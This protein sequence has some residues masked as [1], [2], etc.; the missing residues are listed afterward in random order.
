[1]MTRRDHLR[2]T[3]IVLL[4]CLISGHGLAVGQL[5]PEP[6]AQL[7]NAAKGAS[8]TGDGE[9][10]LD[11]VN[12]GAMPIT[13]IGFEENKGQVKTTDG[14]PAPFVRYRL[15]KGSTSIFLLESGIAYQ[16]ER[17]HQPAGYAELMAEAHHNPDKQMELDALSAKVRWET[18]PMD[19]MLDGADPSSVIITRSSTH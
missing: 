19:M 8:T 16:F 4:A 11:R 13:S 10:M 15:S 12:S 6:L 3:R 7:T 9:A 1:M 2:V 5:A 18:Y 14:Q 17:V